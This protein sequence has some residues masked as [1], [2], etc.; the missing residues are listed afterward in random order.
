M[1]SSGES[2]GAIVVRSVIWVPRDGSGGCRNERERG[3]TG[4]TDINSYMLTS[5][6]VAAVLLLVL[7]VRLNT[8]SV[9]Q[10]RAVGQ[11]TSEIDYTA[12]GSYLYLFGAAAVL[13]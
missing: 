12:E 8:Y 7:G 1:S 6:V 9:G 4:A 2:C 10:G 13:L 5:K 3:C 11:K